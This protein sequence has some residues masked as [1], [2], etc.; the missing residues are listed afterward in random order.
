M[1]NV[2]NERKLPTVENSINPTG[3]MQRDSNPETGMQHDQSISSTV[4]HGASYREE[5]PP[6]NHLET[7][8]AAETVQPTTSHGSFSVQDTVNEI[9]ASSVAGKKK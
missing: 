5:P 8:P 2:Y 7:C 4:N 3:P 1:S 6:P 9:P